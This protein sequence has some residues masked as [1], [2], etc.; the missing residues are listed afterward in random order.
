MS[1]SNLNIVF[2]SCIYT[3]VPKGFKKPRFTPF[4]PLGIAVSAPIGP[5]QPERGMGTWS[6][7]IFS[8]PQ[9][10]KEG[11]R[12]LNSRKCGQRQVPDKLRGRR[13]IT[14]KFSQVR[15]SQSTFS[16]NEL[17]PPFPYL[18]FCRPFFFQPSIQS[19]SGMCMTSPSSHFSQ[20]FRHVSGGGRKVFFLAL[21]S[22]SQGETGRGQ[23][24]MCAECIYPSSSLSSLLMPL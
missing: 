20:D 2:K 8:T 24:P 4:P 5:S 22:S 19:L 15:A 16:H 23:R 13:R 21:P 10:E 17:F 3:I 1:A 12:Q 7:R 11:G 14:K 18:F 9:H 6:C